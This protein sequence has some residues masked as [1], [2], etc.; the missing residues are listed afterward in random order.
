MLF[1][2]VACTEAPPPQPEIATLVPVTA[3]APKVRKPKYTQADLQDSEDAFTLSGI[4]R[5]KGDNDGP[6]TL[7]VWP[8]HP[9]FFGPDPQTLPWHTPLVSIELDKASSF[10]LKVPQ[11]DKRLVLAYKNDGE[12]QGFADERG[13]YLKVQ[14]D[15]SQLVVDCRHNPEWENG[16][17]P[18]TQ[19]GTAK[20]LREA[21]A[22][23][24]TDW[25][26]TTPS[27]RRSQGSDLQDFQQRRDLYE[28]RFA[29]EPNSGDIAASLALVP[30]EAA[31]QA[32]RNRENR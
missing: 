5:C 31:E 4:L 22:P 18:I 2:S 29:K 10:S 6:W 32:A 20:S 11:G 30:P 1:L 8:F 28:R 26:Y 24:D 27:G 9:E 3:A 21:P 23:T 12:T 14:S 16:T 17:A 15:V 19:Q 13:A 7:A 25:L